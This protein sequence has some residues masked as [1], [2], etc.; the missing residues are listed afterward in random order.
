[1]LETELNL[2]AARDEH[3]ILHMTKVTSAEPKKYI[4]DK[5]Y[6]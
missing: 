4:D 5:K 1:M 6:A 2:A 3:M